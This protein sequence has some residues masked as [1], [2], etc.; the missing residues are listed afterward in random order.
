MLRQNKLI[1]K[2]VQSKLVN[3][4]R[5]LYIFNILFFCWNVDEDNKIF[6]LF[7]NLQ[8]RKKT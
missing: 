7:F 6:D 2:M 3:N 4:K 8:P 1:I 5:N